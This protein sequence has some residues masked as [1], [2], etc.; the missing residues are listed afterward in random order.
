MIIILVLLIIAAKMQMQ[1]LK[2]NEQLSDLLE[3]KP[4]GKLEIFHND[5]KMK[6][7]TLE[8]KSIQELYLG[9]QKSISVNM[10]NILK[11]CEMILQSTTIQKTT[12]SLELLSIFKEDLASKKFH[13]AF[14]FLEVL[15]FAQPVLITKLILLHSM[16]AFELF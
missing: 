7:Q 5:I 16:P 6:Y 3:M 12:F 15:Y 11:S 10:S 2:L 14:Y 13:D 8:V 1:I 4:Q 9:S